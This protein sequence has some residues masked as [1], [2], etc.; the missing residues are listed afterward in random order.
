MLQLAASLQSSTFGT[1]MLVCAPAVTRGV[2]NGNV[3]DSTCEHYE[4]VGIVTQRSIESFCRDL[5][6]AVRTFGPNL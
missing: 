1:P 2:G 6:C 3:L 5:P 4:S